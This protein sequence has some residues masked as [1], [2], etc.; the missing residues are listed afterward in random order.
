MRALPKWLAE[1]VGSWQVESAA[2]DRLWLQSDLYEAWAAKQI[3]GSSSMINRAG[4]VAARMVAEYAGRPCI[5]LLDSTPGVLGK[6]CPYCGRRLSHRGRKFLGAG[7]CERC[8]VLVLPGDFS[9]QEPP[10]WGA[11]WV[12]VPRNP[13][14]GR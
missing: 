1:R 9:V 14:R 12:R 2:I 10:R 6:G 7:L 3:V 4:R 13:S 8:S 5:Y 11:R